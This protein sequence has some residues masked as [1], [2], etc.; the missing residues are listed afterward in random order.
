MGKRSEET[1]YQRRDT[2]GKAA[3]EK[4]LNITDHYSEHCKV[5]LDT[6]QKGQNPKH[7]QAPNASNDVK[8]QELSFMGM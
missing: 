5:K 7:W 1:S 4:M 8:H 2:D 3:R 6:H